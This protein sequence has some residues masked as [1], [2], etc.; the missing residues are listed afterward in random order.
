MGTTPETEVWGDGFDWVDESSTVLEGEAKPKEIIAP[1][2][3]ARRSLLNSIS[4][5]LGRPMRAEDYLYPS[6]RGVRA[7][8]EVNNTQQKEK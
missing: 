2:P 6:A 1:D 4:F 5:I 8:D 3:L 7:N